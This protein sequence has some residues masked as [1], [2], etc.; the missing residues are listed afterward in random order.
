MR[1]SVKTK[2]HSPREPNQGCRTIF[3]YALLSIDWI[4]ERPVGSM[5][6]RW[7]SGAARRGRQA[8]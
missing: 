4:V 1:N 5:R 6:P 7:F 3:R 8:T 2:D